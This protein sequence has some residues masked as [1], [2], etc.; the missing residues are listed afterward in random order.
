MVTIPPLPRK[1]TFGDC[2]W[3]GGSIL[4]E[5]YCDDLPSEAA[6]AKQLECCP[7]CEKP[8]DVEFQESIS[9]SPVITPQRS[10]TD[11]RYMAEK[12]IKESPAP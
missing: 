1:S 9:Y 8:I 4:E 3:C 10:K 5:C 12:G 2:P 7:H 11:L 6:A